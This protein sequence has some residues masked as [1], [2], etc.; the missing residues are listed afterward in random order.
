MLNYEHLCSKCKENHICKR[1]LIRAKAHIEP[2]AIVV[3]DFNISLSSMNRSWKEKLKAN[4]LKL[5]E[6]V[7]KTER[8]SVEHF[9]LKQ[10]KIPSS[11]YLIPS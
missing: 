4:T 3:E 1:N 9:T 8:I 7:N 10:N 11:Q 5:K 6:T 2:H